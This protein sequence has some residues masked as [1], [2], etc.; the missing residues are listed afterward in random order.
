M[1]TDRCHDT[2]DVIDAT[3]K[4]QPLLTVATA[5]SLQLLLLAAT[6]RPS[7]SSQSL[8]LQVRPAAGLN[9]KR[10]GQALL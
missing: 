4:G 8:G 3:G 7:T 6:L 5:V 10:E 9:D 1:L 2:T